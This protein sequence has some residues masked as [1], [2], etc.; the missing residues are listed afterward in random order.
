MA[1]RFYVSGDCARDTGGGSIVDRTGKRRAD[2]AGIAVAVLL[3]LLAAVIYWDA[4]NLQL[5]PVYG[6]G[7]KAMPIVIV[8]GLVLLAAGNLVMGL[9]GGLP[10]RE[11]A[12]L[13]AIALILGGLVAMIACI[14]IG[15]GFIP[16]I[17]MLFAATSA[18]F[19]RKAPLTDIAIGLA[20][21]AVI[22]LA[23]DKHLTLSL[24][25]GPLERQL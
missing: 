20:L 24:P 5:N 22:Y 8:A 21:A 9:R 3:L 15:G 23:F 17:A 2:P 1:Y 18:A 4:A 10:A 7:P 25:A 13:K 14:G 16:A 11:P 6:L 19:G 12:D